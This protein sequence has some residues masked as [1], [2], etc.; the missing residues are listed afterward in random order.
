VRNLLFGI[1]LLV[2][3]ACLVWP[4]YDAVGNRIRPLVLGVPF[5]LVWVV[6]WVVLTFLALVVYHATRP[7]DG[8]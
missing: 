2:C 7:A 8:D 6:G 1:Y 5:S 3:C 4:V